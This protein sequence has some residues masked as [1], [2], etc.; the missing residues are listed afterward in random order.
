MRARSAAAEGAT[1]AR[2]KVQRDSASIAPAEIARSLEL[3]FS[4]G[5][6]KS[7]ARCHQRISNAD[8]IDRGICNGCWEVIEACSSR[9]T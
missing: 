9:P 6:R 4:F 3:G 7:C 1:S 8:G 5:P 2:G